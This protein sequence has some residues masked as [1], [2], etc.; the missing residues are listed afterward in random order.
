MGGLLKTNP[1]KGVYLRGQSL[2]ISSVMECFIPHSH[3]YHIASLQFNNVTS[4][5][6]WRLM[7]LLL[8]SPHYRIE[9]GRI[10]TYVTLYSVIVYF[11][12][13]NYCFI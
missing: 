2:K 4:L 12:R 5:T 8:T 6:T 10:F 13:F 3:R 11:L 1:Q 9:L 7:Y